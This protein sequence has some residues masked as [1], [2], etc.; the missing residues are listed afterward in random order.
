[1][2]KKKELIG[3]IVIIMLLT[4]M[5]LCCFGEEDD[6][7]NNEVNDDAN[8]TI[9]LT[10]L[11]KETKKYSMS[12]LK[13][14]PSISKSGGYKKTTG[15]IG[16]PFTLKGVKISYL[17]NEAGLIGES[18]SLE[19][20]ARDG[21]TM[22]YSKSQVEG[23]FIT[24]NS[25]GESLGINQA[26]MILAYEE[27]G[28]SEL[29]GGPLRIVIVGDDSP[30]A[31]GH[32]WVKEVIQLKLLE[33]VEEWSVELMGIADYTMNR[34]TFEAL[35]TCSY[36]RKWYNYTDN[37]DVEYHYEVVPLW[38][39]ISTVDG[40]NAPNNFFFFN[41]FLA[42]VG[43]NISVQAADGFKVIFTSGRIARNNSILVAYKDDGKYLSDSAGGPLCL[44]GKGL[45]GKE[46]IKGIAYINMTD[47]PKVEEWAFDL[48]GLTSI[49]ITQSLFIAMASHHLEWYNFTDEYGTSKHYQGIPLY[50]LLGAVDDADDNGHFGFND[51]LALLGY[52][53]KI[54]AKDGFTTTL[55]SLRIARNRTI[56]LA[57]LN[58]GDPLDESEG[59]VRILGSGLSG[60]E[61]IKNIAEIT[62]ED[63]YSIPHSQGILTVKGKQTG[64]AKREVNV[65]LNEITGFPMYS[66]AGGSFIYTLARWWFRKR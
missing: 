11:G 44:V 26:A 31:D 8:G 20:K 5:F 45:S 14:L 38:I 33:A 32:F 34:T 35:A 13:A 9:V 65:S 17:L 59:P 4:S 61:Q 58:D 49:K 10:V 12:Q 36:H 19:A 60:K 57:Y 40:V 66:G 23:N 27:V 48:I 43:Y 52:S 64:D 22:T 18:Y 24:Y 41:D 2:E 25:A 6:N 37:D 54:K 15:T 50:Y 3:V 42:D 46:R 30:I 51:T 55:D 29:T 39:L 7:G 28:M 16:G 1:M 53:V 63:I 56:L 62:M 21:Y 47:M